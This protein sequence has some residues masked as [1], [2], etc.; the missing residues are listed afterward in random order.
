MLLARTPALSSDACQ[1]IDHLAADHL[2]PER[3]LAG[4]RLNKEFIYTEAP[5]LSCH[6]ATI[7][8][9]GGGLVAAW[10][11]G[12]NEKHPDTE[13]WLSMREAQGWEAPRKLT[14]ER[15]PCWNP[16]LFDDE[17]RLLLFYKVGPRPAAWRGRFIFSDDGGGHWSE[18]E[19]LP[20]G[21]LGPVRNKPVRLGNGRVL[22]PSSTED[23]GW[24]VH[25]EWYSRKGWLRM[26]PV[27]DPDALGAIQPTVLLHSDEHIQLL[28]RTRS[29]AVAASHSHDGGITWSPL[30]ATSLLNPNS[31]IDAVRLS[32]GRFALVHN[33]TRKPEESWGGLRTPLTVSVSRDGERFELVATLEN[34]PGEFSYPA[35]IAAPDGGMHVVYTWRRRRIRHAY[36]E[37]S[38]LRG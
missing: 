19:D 16:V 18:A 30:E 33:P 37:A 26:P 32:D 9:T 12:T 5:Y 21:I 6:A 20:Q 22:C 10:F 38:E 23:D 1:V 34:A 36:L 28:C 13:I 15:E 24:E 11:G 2:A 14:S 3:G 29:G 17:G 4:R 7:E 8:A 25:L 27:A 35:A 31:A